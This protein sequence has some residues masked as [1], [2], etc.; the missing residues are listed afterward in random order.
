MLHKCHRLWGRHAPVATPYQRLLLCSVGKNIK[1]AAT[2]LHNIR[3]NINI[4]AK[5][6]FC[7]KHSTWRATRWKKGI[8]IKTKTRNLYDFVAGL[9]WGQ[10]T[11]SYGVKM[12]WH[13]CA[14]SV[15]FNIC[16]PIAVYLT[17]AIAKVCPVAWQL[18]I[19]IC[20]KLV[21]MPHAGIIIL[22][23]RSVNYSS[24]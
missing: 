4:T 17:H 8:E 2:M 12:C 11:A 13:T 22:V 3:Q 1:H 23:W 21:R 15:P 19:V 14:I 5:I 18:N 16:L 10:L 9:N 24:D 7:A 20:G 6:A